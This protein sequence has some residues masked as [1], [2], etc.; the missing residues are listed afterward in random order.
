MESHDP[1]PFKPWML[2]VAAYLMGHGTLVDESISGIES[3]YILVERVLIPL[4]TAG[5]VAYISA[6]ILRTYA[7]PKLQCRWRERID[8][9]AGLPAE[10]EIDDG[11]SGDQPI[12]L[13]GR[14]K[15]VEISNF[16]AFLRVQ[17]K[18]VTAVLPQPS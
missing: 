15:L 12:D 7:L 4:Y 13:S 2:L 1:T 16:D 8:D 5:V 17:G 9:Q 3:F 6:L 11:E 14:Y 18:S 10:F